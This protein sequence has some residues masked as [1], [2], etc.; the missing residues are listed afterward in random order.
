MAFSSSCRSLP[1]EKGGL[2]DPRVARPVAVFAAEKA[3]GPRRIIIIRSHTGLA[4][5]GVTQL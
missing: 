2:V 4:V 5:T 3:L 1:E